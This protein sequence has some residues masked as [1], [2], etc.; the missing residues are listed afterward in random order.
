MTASTDNGRIWREVAVL[1]GPTQGRTEHVRV[2]KWPARTRKV[3]LRFEMTGNNTAGVQSFRID[4]DYRD[5]MADGTAASVPRRP[6]LERRGTRKDAHRD[7]RSLAG[8]VHDPSR[9]RPEMVSVS[10]EMAGKAHAG[11][12]PGFVSR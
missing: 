11:L 6:S 12:S 8:Q 7:H 9:A 1:R 5:P 4:A 2:D 3:L 10:Y